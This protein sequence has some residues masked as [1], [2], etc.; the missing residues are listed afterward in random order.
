[1]DYKKLIVESFN[2]YNGPNTEVLE[3]L[4]DKDVVFEDPLT[5]VEGLDE[6]KKYYQ[7]AYDPVEDI[8]FD[9]KEIHEAGLTFTCEWDM[10][11]ATKTKALNMGKPFTVRGTSVI[12]F[13]EESN[14]VIRHNDYLDIGEMVYEK[15]PGL[16]KVIKVI[17]SRLS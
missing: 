8:K 9:F 3:R 17:K 1:M 10:T 14:K 11:F 16:G 12:S 5:K 15:I 7:H 4:Y 2:D 13:S 6:L